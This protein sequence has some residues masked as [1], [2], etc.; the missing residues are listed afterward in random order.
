MKT[1]RKD[2]IDELQELEAYFLHK[3]KTRNVMEQQEGDLS[4][5]FFQSVMSSVGVK[6][7]KVVSIQPETRR[8]A[9]YMKIAASF[10]VM[11]TLSGVAYFYASQPSSSSLQQLMAETTSQEI[12]EYLYETGVP[13]DEEFLFEQLDGYVK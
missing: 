3:D 10:L 6:E 9:S 13:T 4:E 7:T 11:L 8:Y 12:L 2:I 1:N 5:D